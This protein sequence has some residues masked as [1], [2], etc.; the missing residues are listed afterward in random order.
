MKMASIREIHTPTLV[1]ITKTRRTRADNLPISVTQSIDT[2]DERRDQSGEEDHTAHPSTEFDEILIEEPVD[3]VL[4]DVPT[5]I[6]RR[7][8]T[9]DVV[10][11][12][13]AEEPDQEGRSMQANEAYQT[14]RQ[15]DEEKTSVGTA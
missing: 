14:L 2:P 6:E 4:S 12:L 9:Q 7:D 11:V 10:A 1:S 3:T 8:R 5:M 13:A 15:P